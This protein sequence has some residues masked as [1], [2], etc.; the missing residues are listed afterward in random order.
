MDKKKDK[1]G[2]KEIVAYEKTQMLPLA[3]NISYIVTPIYVVVSVFLL[4]VFAVLMGINDEKYL[5]QGLLCLGAFVIIS[6][7]LLASV[8]FVRKKVIDIEL[9]RYDFDTSKVEDKEIWD[10][11][12][13][14]ISLKFDRNGMYV[15]DEI[16]YYNHLNKTLVTSNLY[17]RIGIYL[18]FALSEEQVIT[19]FVNPTTL[20]MIE[21]LDIEFDGRNILEY[22]ISNKKEAFEQIYNKGYVTIR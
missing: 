18:Q 14:E 11:S 10:L 20:K 7:I 22:I 17:K 8:P 19:L 1:V 2:L 16:F 6:I 13:D 12:T 21:C 9:E 4:V 3:F 5:V 15:N